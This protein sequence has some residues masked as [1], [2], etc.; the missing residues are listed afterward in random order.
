MG[1]IQAAAVAI[2]RARAD[3]APLLRELN[4]EVQALHAAA[5]PRRYKPLV[6][7]L[8]PF[9]AM[10]R[11]PDAHTILA[12]VRGEPVG[13]GHIVVQRRPEDP[14][15]YAATIVHIDQIAVL[16]GARRRGVGVALIG[17]AKTLA[18]EL[19]ADEVTLNVWSFNTAAR[20]FF[21]DQGFATITER[22]RLANDEC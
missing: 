14:F 19:T 22:R 18:A 1:G 17:Y 16:S 2:R 11:A 5:E 21:A 9:E 7:E 15:H 20:S 3:E 8:A 6:A 10:V 13:Y 12:E 4:R